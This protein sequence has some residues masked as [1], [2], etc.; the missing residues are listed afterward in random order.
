MFF[1]TIKLAPNVT[2]IFQEPKKKEDKIV[3]LPIPI[4]VFYHSKEKRTKK[5][6]KK[7]QNKLH[8]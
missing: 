3:N 1:K 6:Q 8:A 7:K 4:I 5:G 2:R